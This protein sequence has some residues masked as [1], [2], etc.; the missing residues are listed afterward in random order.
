MWRG[1]RVYSGIC[2][3]S[4]CHAKLYFPS[5]ASSSVECTG[6]GQ[7]HAKDSLL[8]VENIEDPEVAL[9]SLLHSV[10]LGHTAS[11]TT[12]DLVKVKG[13]SN[14]HCKLL[15][16]LLTRYGMDKRTGEGKLLSEM[17]QG[18]VFDC[19]VLGDRAFQI[20]S[21]HIETAGYGRDKT[22]SLLYLKNTL[23]AIKVVNDDEERLVPLHVDGDGHC[24]VHAISRGLVGREIFWHALR[25]NLKNHLETELQKYKGLF[26]DFIHEDEWIDIISE[27]DPYF[28]PPDGEGLGL[29]NIHVFGLANVLH[30]PII[31]LDNV[32]GMQSSGDYSGIF[33]PALIRE[34]K[35]MRESILNKPLAVAWSSSGR[36][37][38]IPL[39]G[40]KGKPLPK[41]PSWLIPKAWGLPNELVRRYVEFDSQ[42]HCFIGGERCLQEKYVQRLIKSMDDLFMKKHNISAQLVT[43][44]HQF[45]YKPSGMV[46]VKPET[47]ATATKSAVS[48]GRLYRCLSCKALCELHSDISSEMLKAGGKLYDIAVQTHGPLQEGLNYS[49][50]TEELVC[51]FDAERDT[52]VAVKHKNVTIL[53]CHLCHGPLRCVKSDGSA[54]YMNG[55]R[56]ATPVKGTSQCGCGYK[57]YW[58]GKEYNN[59]PESF[60]ITLEWGGET[61]TETVYWFQYEDDPALN[62]NVYD[63]AAKLV[64]RHFPGE[65]GSERLVQKVVDII[66]RQTARR[67]GENKGARPD[68]VSQGTNV[69]S[70]DQEA[71]V[72]TFTP[73][74]IILMGE[75]KKTLHK[76]E[77]TMSE[78][79]KVLKAKTEHHA[80]VMQKRRSGEGAKKMFNKEAKV[81][82]Q[83]AVIKSQQKDPQ[84]NLSKGEDNQVSAQPVVKRTEKK[85]RLST[86][87]GKQCMLTLSVDTTF[88]QL[89]ELI[90]KELGIPTAQIRIR[91]GFPPRELHPP[92][93]GL[94]ED[95]LPLQ[96]GDRIMV[97]HLKPPVPEEQTPDVVMSELKAQEGGVS[98][99]HESSAQDEAEK[100]RQAMASVL[101]NALSAIGGSDMWEAAQN[102]YEMFERG[103]FYYSKV[104]N[105]LGPLQPNQHFTLPFFP[106]KVFAYNADKDRLDLCLGQRHIQVQ[107]LDDESL[108]L[109]HTRPMQT[110]TSER[111]SSLSTE[112]SFSGAIG[113]RDTTHARVAFSGEGRT[114]SSA[115]S[116]QS[117]SA[118]AEVQLSRV[119]SPQTTMDTSASDFENEV[120]AESN[121]EIPDEEVEEVN[122]E[123]KLVSG[124]IVSEEVSFTRSEHAAEMLD[125]SPATF[126]PSTLQGGEIQS[127]GEQTSVS[128]EGKV[129]ETGMS[130]EMAVDNEN[131]DHVGNDHEDEQG[132][133]V[134]GRLAE[135]RDTLREVSVEQFGESVVNGLETE[136]MEAS[137]DQGYRDSNERVVN[138]IDASKMHEDQVDEPS[139]RST[140]VDS[141]VMETE[142]RTVQE[143]GVTDDVTQPM[144]DDQ[145]VT[146]DVIQDG[147]SG[148]V[149]DL[150]PGEATVDRTD[151]GVAIHGS[152]AMEIDTQSETIES[153][154]VPNSV[155][156]AG[157]VQPG[158]D[159]LPEAE[160]KTDNN[161]LSNCGDT[162]LL[163]S[164]VTLSRTETGNGTVSSQASV[165]V[166]DNLMKENETGTIADS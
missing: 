110:S 131:T 139:L 38:F 37:H 25:A 118:K 23:E 46:G 87:D 143:D 53:D 16:P 62:S 96:H 137:V 42:G 91:Y 63:V 142:Q 125:E 24:L 121:K 3:D 130:G 108:R 151:D 94:E 45:V 153:G 109:A 89:Q 120:F 101:F 4:E 92:N 27:A 166:G 60:P 31:L 104:V 90:E 88:K 64:Q 111:A 17:G 75:K 72:S 67:E 34:E 133:V 50:P 68:F 7:H 81:A 18:N 86:S 159:L 102:C 74:K 128:E 58:N 9:R 123:R 134:E 146:G 98:D 80:A 84:A 135:M 160:M 41:L 20:E 21:E 76:E 132:M 79:E 122:K 147:V 145:L 165:A 93:E 48:D 59:M 13:Y 6:C 1:L 149:L 5:Y 119:R 83:Q 161:Q 148:G 61:V 30:R 163:H 152:I 100:Q 56:T 136:N 113:H 116:S 51:L 106:N 114:L 140:R 82:K 10:L 39:V 33:L 73:S 43:E 32:S 144:A 49:F 26:R 44:V 164:K 57:H 107:P 54:V 126:T 69:E 70:S 154:L 158:S 15:S 2:P 155:C 117:E 162:S 85:V 14:Y 8:N 19:A 71:N 112:A 78:K 12:P 157:D 65:F 156:V 29:R 66:L 52:L 99:S 47:V 40:I 11:K 77:L 36:N 138:P 95:P 115:S 129:N 22:G 150:N 105:D 103:G 55:D 127:A 28:E 97:E 141:D 35:C 124:L